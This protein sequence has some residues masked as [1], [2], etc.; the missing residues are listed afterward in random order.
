VTRRRAPRLPFVVRLVRA[1]KRLFIAALVGAAVA[2]LPVGD[3][4]PATR[5]IVGWDVGVALYLVLVGHV[6]ATSTVE[7]IRAHAAIQDEGRL[8]ILILTVA[9]GLVSLGAII[10]ELGSATDPSAQELIVS[11]LTIFL[12]WSFT[13]TIFALHYAHEFYS[14]E[15]GE[16]AGGLKFPGDE[17]PD[18]W[19]FVYFSFVVGMTSQV[20]DVGVSARPI[21]RTVAAHG[22]V[23]FIFNAAILALTVNIAGSVVLK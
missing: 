21:R 9:A 17:D 16:F 8:A 19:D 11:I 10:A 2:A 6:M 5:G 20:S 15:G 3:A 13:H 12:S 23:S 14:E 1:R 22:V 18:Y 7:E 4:F